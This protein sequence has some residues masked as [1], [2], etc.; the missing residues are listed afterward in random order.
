MTA[1]L[2]PIEIKDGTSWL[3]LYDQ[4]Q[5][6]LW[7]LLPV[8]PADVDEAYTEA[9]A[10][11]IAGE[12]LEEID[13]AG[14]MDAWLDAAAS[15][16]T[17]ALPVYLAPYNAPMS[18]GRLPIPDRRPAIVRLLARLWSRVDRETRITGGLT[19]FA[20]FV[21][22]LVLLDGHSRIAALFT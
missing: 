11:R 2:A 14:G 17:S 6:D 7:R 12:L 10:D 21:F 22:L 18:S 13:R 19:L 8:T 15:A 4:L 9:H 5:R 1:A 16:P 20:L 3:D